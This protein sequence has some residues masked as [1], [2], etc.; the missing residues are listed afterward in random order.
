MALPNPAM[1]V[2]TILAAESSLRLRIGR[3]LFLGPLRP[4][5]AQVPAEVVF[6]LNDGGP[7][8]VP[9]LGNSGDFHRASVEV[10]LRGGPDNV[11]ASETLARGCMEALQRQ[12]PAG[13]ITMLVQQSQPI[14][15]GADNEGRH[16]WGIRV[17]CWHRT[18]T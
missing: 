16:L 1:A 5:G 13:Y 7:A 18:T 12:Q 9:Y 15:Q 4:P 8:P 14:Y 17:E 6:C 11:E 10:T 3:N 2:A